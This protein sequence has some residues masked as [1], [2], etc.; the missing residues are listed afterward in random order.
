MVTPYANVAAPV[1]EPYRYGLLAA[2]QVVP[3]S[4]PHWAM[5]VQYT[6]DGC[7]SGGVWDTRCGDPFTVVL[8]KTAVANQFS[9][10]FT[11][12]VGP[13]EASIDGGAFAPMVDGAVFVETT[14]PFVAVFRETS[15]LHRTVTISGILPGAAQGTTYSGA[16]SSSAANAAKTADGLEVVTGEGFTVY[17][18]IDC[19]IVGINDP[20][21]TASRRLAGVEQRLVE[22]YVWEHMLAVPAAV[23]PTG[24]D[25]AVSLKAGIAAL[26][27]ALGSTYGGV[28]VIHAPRSLSPYA[29]DRYQIIRD[30]NKLRTSLDTVWAFGGGYTANT[31]PD[32]S[33]AG[34]GEQWLYA[35]GTAVVRRGEVFVP[36]DYQSGATNLSLN[37]AMVIAERQYV[38]TLDCPLFAVN[39][40]IEA[41]A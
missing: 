7:V 26:E 14:S 27:G 30:R 17:A 8:T 9:V 32:G 21:G 23:L 4:S 19:R 24:S 40:D 12:D 5:G 2:A 38:V 34:V 35:T 31:G 13:Y 6:T 15:G 41:E 25:T 33:E 1:L 20:A 16:S 18:G 29:A 22:E 36:A 11:P 10:N 28:G 39:V 37:D 3:D